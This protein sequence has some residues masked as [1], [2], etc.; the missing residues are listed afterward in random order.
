MIVDLF[1]ELQRPRPWSDGHEHAVFANALD[2]ARLADE[3][4]YG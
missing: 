2:Q 1:N 4:G 3:L